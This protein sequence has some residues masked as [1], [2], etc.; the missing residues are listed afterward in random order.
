VVWETENGSEGIVWF[1]RRK[2]EVRGLC[3]LG[4]GKWKGEK[5]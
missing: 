5:S 4:D 3:G 2:M 1:G